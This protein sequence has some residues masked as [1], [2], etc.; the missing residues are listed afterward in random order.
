M[1]VLNYPFSDFALK[2]VEHI[3]LGAITLVSFILLFKF[4]LF[5]DNLRTK[6]LARITYQKYKKRMQSNPLPKLDHFGELLR[7]DEEMR[8]QQESGQEVDK[9]L[10]ERRKYV[11]AAAYLKAEMLDLTCQFLRSRKFHQDSLSEPDVL[12]YE[13]RK[14]KGD[15]NPFSQKP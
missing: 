2:C 1:L 5:L 3:I 7:I 8:K 14:I 11:V 4:L 15:L 13:W 10:L 9:S 6:I 12:E